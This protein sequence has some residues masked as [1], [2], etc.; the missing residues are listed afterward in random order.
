MNQISAS[1]D[2]HG[3]LLVAGWAAQVRSEVAEISDLV[4]RLS[5]V[6]ADIGVELIHTH[7]RTHAR[8]H[9]HSHTCESYLYWF[10]G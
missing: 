10:Y 9:A 6:M 2:I 4:L 3:R 8:S 7:A 5:D 1:A